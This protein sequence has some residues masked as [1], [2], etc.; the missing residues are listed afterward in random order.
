MNF[1]EHLQARKNIYITLIIAMS[2]IGT[3]LSFSASK[4]NF[5]RWIGKTLSLPSIKNGINNITRADNIYR[6]PGKYRAVGLLGAYYIRNG[7]PGFN[8]V[9][10]TI[11]ETYYKKLDK[12]ILF[13]IG[14]QALDLGDANDPYKTFRPI[15]LIKLD[16]TTRELTNTEFEENY[17]KII[18]SKSALWVSDENRFTAALDSYF[19]IM[20]QFSG[21]LFIIFALLLNLCI[22]LT[23]NKNNN[24][25]KEAIPGERINPSFIVIVLIAIIIS[26]LIAKVTIKDENTFYSTTMGALLGFLLALLVYRIG[27]YFENKANEVTKNENTKYIYQLYKIELEKNISHITHLIEKKWIP[28]Y[29][30]K[31]ITRD[32]LWGELADFSRD[33]VLMEKLNTV[34]SE[35]ELINSKFELMNAARMS[36]VSAT[37]SNEMQKIEKEIEEQLAGSIGLGQKALELIDDCLGIINKNIEEIDKNKK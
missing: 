4:I 14:Y 16:D 34:Y 22:T 10:K 18:E 20:I 23:S 11:E 31:T 9:K 21:T 13:F 19:R 27:L 25:V 32:S 36:K 28:F 35:F 12:D 1:K 30:L 3:S 7:E 17:V 2:I 37:D 8:F 29:R 26:I 5:V 24:L 15:Y 33:I 6:T